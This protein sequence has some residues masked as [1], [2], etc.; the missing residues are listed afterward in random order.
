M[1]PVLGLGNVKL[2]DQPVGEKGNGEDAWLGADTAGMK[3]F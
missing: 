1:S 2:G 3:N